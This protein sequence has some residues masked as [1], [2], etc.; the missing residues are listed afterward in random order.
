MNLDKLLSLK[1]FLNTV[2]PQIQDT[3][4]SLN[5][6]NIRFGSKEWNGSNFFLF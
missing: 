3:V 2:R 5:M 1:L 6:K 4:V